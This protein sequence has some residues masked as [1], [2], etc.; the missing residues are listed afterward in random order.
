MEAPE[1]KTAKNK[2]KTRPYWHVDVK[3]IAG[4]IFTPVFAVTFLLF[5]LHQATNETNGIKMSSVVL[6]AMYAPAVMDSADKVEEIKNIIRES[7]EKALKPFPG[8][9]VE[10][11]EEDI[12]N[13][14]VEEIT[15]RVFFELAKNIYEFDSAEM[16]F[17]AEGKTDALSNLG[18]MAIFTRSGH[19]YIGK[20][21]TYSLLISLVFLILL[22]RFSYS[23]G[24][25]ISPGLIF[26]LVG[27]P[28]VLLLT[29]LQ[30]AQGNPPVVLEGEEITLQQRVSLFISI[31]G[32]EISEFFIKNY[33]I[34]TVS[35]FALVLGGIVR[36]VVKKHK[37]K[38]TLKTEL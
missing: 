1:I 4:L 2:T 17:N 12:N 14:S 38:K 7:P 25:L 35:G 32:P 13:Y 37:I 26:I 8:I 36:G 34:L 29:L 15:E 21:L 31:V 27:L 28:A 3:W 24:R 10:I 5:N 20:I 9:D 19:Q 6:E 23:S 18:M 22:V 16:K 33:I 30:K 11:T